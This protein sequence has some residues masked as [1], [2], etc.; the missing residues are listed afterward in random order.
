MLRQILPAIFSPGTY[1]YS[2]RKVIVRQIYFTSLQIIFPFVLTAIFTGFAFTSIF[3]V[4]VDITGLNEYFGNFFSNIILLEIAPLFIIL[5]LSLRS[6]AAIC[7]EIAVMKVNR[8]T[9]TLKTLGIDTIKYLFIPRIVGFTVSAFLLSILFV[10]IIISSGYLLS[11]FH[12]GTDFAI[13]FNMIARSMS[14]FAIVVT[15]VKIIIFAFFISFL[16]V[17]SGMQ[18]DYTNRSIPIAVL[19]G[20]VRIIFSIIIVEVLTLTLKLL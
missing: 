16:A 9:E 15:I 12:F 13:Y 11:F 19:Q 14:W 8:E 1:L 10:I 2:V 4:F 18:A 20:M 3:I 6:G 7:T 5:F 17:Y